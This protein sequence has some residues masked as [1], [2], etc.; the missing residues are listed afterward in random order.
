MDAGLLK[1]YLDADYVVD[2]EPPVR[3]RVG[4]FSSGLARLMWA[5][6]V[7]SVA[8][9]TAWNPG[10]RCLGK[11]ANRIRQRTL[12]AGLRTI[13]TRFLPGRGVDPNGRWEAEE[14][15][16]ALGLGLETALDIGRRHGQNAVVWSGPEA[17]PRLVMT[18]GGEV[19][20][21]AR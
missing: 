1:A 16:L 10:S 3:L 11:M 21:P 6:G 4:V 14:S 17:V 2:A 8:L 19:G 18:G 13:G 12:E 15:V 5:E 7:S 20:G 9:V